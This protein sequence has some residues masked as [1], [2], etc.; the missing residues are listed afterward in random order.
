MT[1]EELNNRINLRQAVHDELDRLKASGISNNKLGPMLAGVYDQQTGRYYF[2]IND[3]K[4]KTPINLHPLL[5]ERYSNMP[6][7]ILSSYRRTKGAGSHAE[8]FALN[9]ALWAREAVGIPASL[10]DLYL[11][12]ISTKRISDSIPVAGMPAPRCPH[13]EYLTIGTKYYPEV[14]KYGKNGSY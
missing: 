11:N 8:I 14:L 7:D 2:G 4:G 13:C 12:V 1:K 5:M 10:D 3:L 9:D 6:E